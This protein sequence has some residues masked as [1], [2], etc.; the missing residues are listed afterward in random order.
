MS[1]GNDVRMKLYKT[2]DNFSDITHGF[3]L[4]QS[5]WVGS[6]NNYFGEETRRF[7]FG[8]MTSF[9]SGRRISPSTLIAEELWGWYVSHDR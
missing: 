7:S 6:P 9:V 4:Q 5:V 8:L 1:L 3:S 2:F